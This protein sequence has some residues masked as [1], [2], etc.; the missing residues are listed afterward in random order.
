MLIAMLVVLPMQT[1]AEFWTGYR[2]AKVMQTFAQK[3]Y[4]EIFAEL[5][6]T[7]ERLEP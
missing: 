7:Q 2:L 4:C 6:F 5:E 1:Q 3:E